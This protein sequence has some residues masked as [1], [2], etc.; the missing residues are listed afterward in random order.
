MAGI[1]PRGYRQGQRRRQLDFMGLG[2][3]QADARGRMLEPDNPEDAHA[4]DQDEHP[5]GKKSR[6]ERRGTLLVEQPPRVAE[7]ET[8]R[9]K[10]GDERPRLAASQAVLPG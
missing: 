3:P 8:I 2:L 6:H 7:M 10:L 4:D 9:R 5:P 1:A